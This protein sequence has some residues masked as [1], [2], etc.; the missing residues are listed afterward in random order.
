MTYLGLLVDRNCFDGPRDDAWVEAW[1]HVNTRV[2]GGFYIHML[3]R[4]I[5]LQTWPGQKIAKQLVCKVC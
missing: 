5:G 1:G 4:V 2:G 3:D